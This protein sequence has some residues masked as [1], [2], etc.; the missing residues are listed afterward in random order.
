MPK[1]RSACADRAETVLVRYSFGG[2]GVACLSDGEGD[3]AVLDHVL[4][5]SA[6][7]TQSA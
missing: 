7:Y 1:K 2:T 5:L 4:D 3:V 6:H